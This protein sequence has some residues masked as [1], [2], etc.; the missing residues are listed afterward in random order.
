MSSGVPPGSAVDTDQG[1][2]P[3][4]ESR[5]FEHFATDR[6]LRRLPHHHEPSGERPPSGERFVPSEHQ[7]DLPSVDH[8]AIDRQRRGHDGGTGV[9]P[10]GGLPMGAAPGIRNQG[11]P[12]GG[13]RR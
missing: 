11:P 12:A 3:R 7:D 2:H 5:L 6:L 8:D 10:G 4:P 1:L 9:A 13:S